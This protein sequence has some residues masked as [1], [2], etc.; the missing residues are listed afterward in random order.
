MTKRPLWQW[1]ACL[2]PGAA[3]VA[4]TAIGKLLPNDEQVP[5]SL[6]GLAFAFLLCIVMAIIL[7]R[8]AG[9]VSKLIGL[10]L[11]FIIPLAIVNFSIAFGGC[12]VLNP[13]FRIQ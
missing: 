11:L 13:Y 5:T 6:L 10:T 4:I 9:S 8:P 7:A 2:A 1:F 12:L 3:S